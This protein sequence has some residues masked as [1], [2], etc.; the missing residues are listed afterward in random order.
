MCIRDSLKAVVERKPGYADG[1]SALGDMYLWSDRPAE[2]AAAY[3]R[4]VE[5][6]PNDPAATMARGRAPVSYTH[7]DVYKRQRSWRWGT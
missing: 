4:W 7:L 6:M 1:W 2:A 5:L 3:T